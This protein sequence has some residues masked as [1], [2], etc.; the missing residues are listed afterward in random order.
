[1]ISFLLIAVPFSLFISI[2][3]PKEEKAMEDRF[4]AEYVEW[5]NSTKRLIPF[6]Y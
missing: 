6:L 4:G 2:R 5:K 3:I 1:L